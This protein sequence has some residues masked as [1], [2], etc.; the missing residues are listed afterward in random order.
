MKDKNQL[1][2]II[3]EQ[4]INL[5]VLKSVQDLKLNDCWI[6]A[7][8]IRNAVW[9]KLHEKKC[10]VIDYDIDV[11]FYDTENTSVDYEKERSCI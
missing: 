5:E 6:G 3:N 7:G 2:S 11:V 1:F 9:N 10:T 4:P 8:F